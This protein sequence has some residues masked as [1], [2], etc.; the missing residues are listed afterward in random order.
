MACLVGLILRVQFIVLLAH[1]GKVFLRLR[2]GFLR[3]LIARAVCESL[4]K[5]GFLF[6]QFSDLLFQL[7][8][9]RGFLVQC[10]GGTFKILVCLFI[11]VTGNAGA[12]GNGLVQ[13]A[14]ELA[15]ACSYNAALVILR[16]SDDGAYLLI[17][18]PGEYCVGGKNVPCECHYFC[19]P[20][21]SLFA[22]ACASNSA[23]CFA[24]AAFTA[25]SI[26]A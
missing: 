14:V 22:L 11:A 13:L 17:G 1:G 16:E 15:D 19:P 21:F 3:F 5:T 7:A 12:V 26:S 20:F 24:N 2:Q 25:A 23:A 10:L 8:R 9:L 4:F 6:R 18:Q